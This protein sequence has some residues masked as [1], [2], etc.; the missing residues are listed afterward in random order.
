[1][2]KKIVLCVSLCCILCLAGV[3]A[4]RFIFPQ[5]GEVQTKY[6]IYESIEMLQKDAD[7]IFEIQVN[8]KKDN[9][10]N[11][12]EDNYPANGY[13]LTTANVIKSYSGNNINASILVSIAEPYYEYITPLGRYV[14]TFEGYSPMKVS[15]KYL[16]FLKENKESGY[17]TI[18][19]IYQGKYL[20][21]DNG[22]IENIDSATREDMEIGDHGNIELY[23]ALFKSVKEFKESIDDK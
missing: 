15:G 20:L 3:Y 4:S 17:Y 9:I 5:I 18:L 22:M 19:G 21:I 8:E 6:K 11:Y 14:D 23:K 13:T 12:T 2:K 7:V 10:V 1:M 16:L